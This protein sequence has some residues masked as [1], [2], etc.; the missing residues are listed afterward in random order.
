MSP[1]QLQLSDPVLVT[2]EF[3]VDR[4]WTDHE[5]TV[6]VLMHL[7]TFMRE[8]PGMLAD[9]DAAAASRRANR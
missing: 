4:L 3:R 7:I 8:L 1:E 5:L 9:N 2:I 6:H